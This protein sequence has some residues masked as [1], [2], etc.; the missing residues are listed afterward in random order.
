MDGF[1]GWPRPLVE[2][3]GNWRSKAF[4][5]ASKEWPGTDLF[6][7]RPQPNTKPEDSLRFREPP[8]FSGDSEVG[9]SPKIRFCS[10]WFLEGWGRGVVRRIASLMIWNTHRH[11]IKTRKR[12]EAKRPLKK[13]EKCHCLN[14]MFVVLLCFLDI[15]YTV[16]MHVYTYYVH[17]VAYTAIG[18]NTLN[19]KLLYF[20]WSPPWHF[21]TARLDFMSAWSGQVR[22][23]IQL[24]SWNAFCYSQLR[25]LT[26]S[27]LLTYLLTF[28]LT[29]LLKFFLT[30][31]LTFFLTYLLTFFLTY[32]LTCFLTYLLTFFLTHQR[33]NIASTAS[34]KSHSTNSIFT[35]HHAAK[36]ISMTTLCLSNGNSTVAFDCIGQP[37]QEAVESKDAKRL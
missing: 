23:D 37:R 1:P 16:Y 9:K 30:Y 24:I 22:V 28:F 29:Y 8:G 6:V 25:R 11:I 35:S 7:I 14:N 34:H 4:Q 2:A 20:E 12:R 36:V 31:L 18:K 5:D 26:G 21:K 27:N 3:A 19:E 10:C 13:A 17:L 33:Q 32:L 15:D